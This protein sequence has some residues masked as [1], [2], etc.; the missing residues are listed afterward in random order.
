[1]P[2]YASFLSSSTA[3]GDSLTLRAELTGWNTFGEQ[4]S[5]GT[6]TRRV[7]YRPWMS[8]PLAPLSITVPSEASVSV[9]AVRLEDAAGTVL[10]R[11]FTTFVV[12]GDAPSSGTLADGRRVRALRVRATDTRD[13]KWSLK[14][15]SVL[16][17]KKLNGAGSGFVEYRIP[18]PAGLTVRDVASATFLVEASA[19]RLNGKDR[20]STVSGGG[21]YM[22]GGGLQDRSQ[23]KNSYPMTSA[24]KFP[25]AVTIRVNGEVAAHREL[26]DDPA[27]SRGILSW[28]AQP[29]NRTLTEAGSYGELLRVPLSAAV[30]AASERSGEIVIRLEVSDALPGGL[31]VFGARFGRYPLDPTV[32]FVMRDP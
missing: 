20:D 21:D 23:N 16:G 11:N 26:P 18:W 9:L 1:V 3:Y 25:S 28:N 27:D 31:A 24:H 7:P 5:Y 4:K 10:H 19:K 32:L 17:D 8:A 2:L 12:G 6:Y 14:H 13:A 29:F 15:W 30:I 22:R